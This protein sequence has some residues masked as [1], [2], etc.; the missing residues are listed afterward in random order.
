MTSQLNSTFKKRRASLMIYDWIV[1]LLSCALLMIIKPSRELPLSATGVAIHTAALSACVIG[2]RVLGRAYKQVW[3]Y[4]RVNSYIRLILCDFAAAAVYVGLIWLT[5][6]LKVPLERI[7]ILRALC[8]VMLSLLG[9]ITMRLVYT[10]VYE[11]A[12]KGGIKH[13]LLRRAMSWLMMLPLD[14]PR[15]VALR[16]RIRIAIIGAGRVGAMLAEELLN[17]P[18]AV[19]EPVCFVDVD[20]EKIGRD[21]MGIPVLPDGA[22]IKDKLTAMLVQEIVFTMQTDVAKRQKLFEHYKDM[23][24]RIKAYSF[25]I[26]ATENNGKRQ[27]REFDIEELLF[28]QQI[29]SMSEEAK[30]FY[31]GKVVLISGGGGSIG[32]ELARQIA[33]LQPKQLV[34]L[35]IYENNVYDIQQEMRL[36]YGDK[37]NLAVEIASVRDK[38]QLDKVFRVYRPEIVLHAAAHKHVPLMEHNCSEAVKNNVF[39]TKNMVDAAE[40]YGVS[41]FI[42]ISTDKAVNPT[43]VMGATKRMCEMLVQSASTYGK[44]KYSCT[45]FGNVL[46]S[47]GSVIPLFKRQIAYGGPV[48]I[49]D[50]RIIRYFMTIPEAAQLVLASGAMAKNGELFVLDMGQPIKILDLA[51]NMIR[52]SGAQDVEIVETGLRPGEKLYEEL[53]VKTEELDK[54]DNSLIFIERDTSLTKAEIDEKL[55]VLALAC[56]TED[57]EAVR[58]ALHSV[59]PTFHTPEEVN[60]SAEDAEEM[61]QQR[62][63]IIA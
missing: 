39:G 11:L 5:R 56:E 55:K 27:I 41:K 7:A 6:L 62:E 38:E 54:T 43:N 34:L 53:L 4:S 22:D 14:E 60:A 16:N 32:S 49:T 2:V 47:A 23:G 8:V 26:E 51:E 18:S 29:D 57:D 12:G 35:D 30:A 44:V 33:R 46:G 1:L 15:K 3:R 52:L 58:F 10:W 31:K 63:A 42:M 20:Q 19:Y 17:N 48:T 13:P 28:R 61:R 59:V 9:A 24:F 40:K 45:R 21:I 25:P 37:L 50:K 36:L